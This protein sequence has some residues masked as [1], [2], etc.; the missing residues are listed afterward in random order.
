MLTANTRLTT[1][2]SQA[3]CTLDH[4]AAKAHC[5]PSA[6]VSGLFHKSLQ[7]YASAMAISTSCLTLSAPISLNLLHPRKQTASLF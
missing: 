4:D 6:S 7:A 3:C 1:V 5:I 2:S